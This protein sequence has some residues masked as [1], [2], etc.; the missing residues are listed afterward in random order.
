[1]YQ[2]LS[3]SLVD[4]VLELKGVI[5]PD[6]ASQA[7]KFC[8]DLRAL[9]TKAAHVKVDLDI[10]KA[11]ATVTLKI[12]PRQLG[13]TLQPIASR[14]R[15][16]FPIASTGFAPVPQPS[17]KISRSARPGLSRSSKSPAPPTVS[18]KAFGPPSSKPRRSEPNAGLTA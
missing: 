9:D 13:K 7:E 4:R 3:V 8:K 17:D 6:L 15:P 11:T 2:E 12:Y 5:A 10:A 18:V 14:V 1:M 16:V